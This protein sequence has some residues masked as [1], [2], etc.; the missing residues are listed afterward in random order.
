MHTWRIYAVTF[1]GHDIEDLR[2][3]A[4]HRGFDWVDLEYGNSLNF[5]YSVLKLL[6]H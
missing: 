3:D 6:A 1:F 5:H 4:D 2:I